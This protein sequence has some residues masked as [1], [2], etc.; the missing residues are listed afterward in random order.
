M[1]AAEHH[2]EW[3]ILEEALASLQTLKSKRLNF[4]ASEK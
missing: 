3:Q 1:L 4:R 2:I